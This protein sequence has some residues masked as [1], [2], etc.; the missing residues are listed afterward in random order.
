MERYTT[1][2][3]FFDFYLSEHDKPATRALH[4]LGSTFGITALILT[5]AQRQPLWLL[6]GLGTG[7]GCAWAAHFFVEKNRPA[8]F[9]YPL[10][11]FIGDYH[12]FGLWLSGRLPERLKRF[13]STP[14]TTPQG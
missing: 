3:A 1:Y 8:T 7:Y 14:G 9:T 6:A 4:Y 2:A 13:R 12:M 5:V 10:W 11:S